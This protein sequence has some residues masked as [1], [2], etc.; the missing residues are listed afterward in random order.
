MTLP[1][2]VESVEQLEELL[3]DPSPGVVETLGRLEGDVIVLGAAGKM[4]PSLSR[5]ARLASD[6]ASVSR[7]VIAVSRF[8]SEGVAAQLRDAGVE[9][10]R[11]DLLDVDALMA[12][13]DAP[14]VVYMAGRKFGSTGNEPLTWAMNTHLPSL[15]AR[16]Y[17]ASRIAVFSTCV[18]GMTPV[19]GGGPV[20]TDPLHAEGEYY[21]SCLGRERI[22]EYFSNELSID[23]TFIR[24]SYANELR[25]GVRSDLARKILAGE[26]IDVT[27]GHA[28]I[29]WQG[30]ANA[31]AL[32]T[33]DHA[34]SPPR[35]FNVTGPE[36]LSVRRAAESL[37]RIIDRPVSFTGAE[38]DDALLCDAAQANRLF[39]P[40]RVDTDRML[41]WVADWVQRG[42]ESLGKPTHYEVRDG[43]F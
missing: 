6:A 37:G 17:R 10:I 1:N 35:P 12:L 14:N 11:C 13:P 39:G 4:G 32:Q 9:T 23:M 15:V 28:H 26:P 25:Y 41:R 43:K 19:S 38:A 2:T 40:P 34:A 42:G 33:L 24:L 7:R 27:M 36:L 20:E 29:I 8:S 3:S 21:A 16:R 22:F 30:D 5:M 18:Y 31:M